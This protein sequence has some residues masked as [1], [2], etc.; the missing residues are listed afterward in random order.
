MDVARYGDW[1]TLAYTNAKVRENYSR[2]FRIRFP[3][4]ELPAARP[5]RTTPI[6][7][8]LA[9]RA[10]GVRRLL[11]PRARAVVRADAPRRPSE[12][13]TSTAP[14]P[15]RMSAAECRAVREAVGLLEISNYGKFEVTGAGRAEWLSHIMANRVPRG[16][17][18]RADAHAERARQADRRLHLCRV[19]RGPRVPR[20]APMPR[21]STTCAGS[22]ATCRRPGVTRAALRHGV[23]RP[24]GR[25]AALARAAAGPGARRSVD[26]GVSVPVVP[27]HGCRHGAGARRARLLHR[28]SRLRDLGD[29]AIISARCTIC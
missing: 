12:T 20:S 19:A 15:M 27:A 4:E 14:T 6:Y 13:I 8:R 5:L 26:S 21:K 7:E 25:R 2:R 17:A 11:R 3:N 22:S 16:R 18:H 10:R 1:A 29:H 24:V 9:G 28:R 23:R